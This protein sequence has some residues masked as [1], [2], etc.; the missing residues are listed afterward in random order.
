MHVSVGDVIQY[1]QT[2]GTVGEEEPENLPVA[3]ALSEDK[4][5]DKAK[6]LGAKALTALALGSALLGGGTGVAVPW[7]L[8]AFDKPQPAATAPVEDTDT[9]RRVEIQGGEPTLE[10]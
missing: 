7:L 4:P 3:K 5:L 10:W 6:V 9:V 1:Y 8:G 2:S